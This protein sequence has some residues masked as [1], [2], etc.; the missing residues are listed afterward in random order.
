MALNQWLRRSFVVVAAALVIYGLLTS[1]SSSQDA[2]KEE[3]KLKEKPKA[4]AERPAHSL[5]ITITADEKGQTSSLTVG[6]AKL[7]DGPLDARMLR[8]LDRRLNDVFAIEGKPFEQVLLRVDPKLSSGDLI[9]VINVCD[10][11]RFADGGPIKKMSFVVL[12]PN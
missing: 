1:S 11:Q 2:D 9:K 5:T 4:A 10:V 8:M 3:A 6:L 7:F 12:T